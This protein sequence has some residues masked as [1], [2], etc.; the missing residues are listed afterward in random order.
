MSGKFLEKVLDVIGTGIGMPQFVN[1]SVMVKRA[2]NLFGDSKKGISLEKARRT[3]IGACVGSYIPYETGH[4]V[5][6]QPNLGKVIELVMN[7]GFDP[8]TKKQV[9]PKTGDPETFKTFEEL[10]AAFEKQLQ[11]NEEVLRRGAWIAS[12]LCADFLPVPWRSLLTGGCIETGTEVWNGGAN[13][14]TVAQIVVGGIDAANS[15]MA[16]KKLVYDDKK[17]TMAELQESLGRQL[18][19][20]IREGPEAVLRGRAQARQRHP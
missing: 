17:I 5:E 8:R 20:R 3:C 14:Y 10:Y 13:Y 15:L 18:G 9:G 6:G 1:G 4:P 2:L 7:N 16:V 19:G 11:F 12:M